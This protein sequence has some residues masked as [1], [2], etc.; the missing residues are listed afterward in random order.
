MQS[1]G[2]TEPFFAFIIL[3]TEP[4][5]GKIFTIKQ[6]TMKNTQK[7]MQLNIYYDIYKQENRQTDRQIYTLFYET[8]VDNKQKKI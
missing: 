2:E 1:L 6:K 4:I 7:N 3:K 8:F 5:L